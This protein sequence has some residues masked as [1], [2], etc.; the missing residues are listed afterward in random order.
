M[1]RNKGNTEGTARSWQ[2]TQNLSLYEPSSRLLPSLPGKSSF[3]AVGPCQAETPYMRLAAA[4]RTFWC[5][6]WW[7]ACDSQPT[8]QNATTETGT[9]HTQTRIRKAATRARAGQRGRA[10]SVSKIAPPV[11]IT[12]QMV[13]EIQNLH[14][15]DPD[16]FVR[17]HSTDASRI[18]LRQTLNPLRRVQTRMRKIGHSA[19]APNTGTSLNTHAS[20]IHDFPQVAHGH[21]C[22]RRQSLNTCALGKSQSSQNREEDTDLAD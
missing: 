1:Q 16:P 7:A 10:L 3:S 6:D 13:Q 22:D 14:L 2:C 15:A 19:C 9:E 5:H 18:L 21:R 20:S 8:R 17:S 12:I 4:A 11:P